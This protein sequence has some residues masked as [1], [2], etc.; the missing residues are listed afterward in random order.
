[1]TELMDT[2]FLFDVDNTLLDNDRIQSDLGKHLAENYGAEVRDRFGVIF[3]Q[4]RAELGYADYLGALERYRLEAMHDPKVLRI[5]NWLVDYPFQERLYPNA[6][7]VVK[8][9]KQA[10]VTAILS[11]GDAVF[12]PRK[13]EKSGLWPVFGDNVLIYVHKELELADVES[14]FPARHYVLIDDKL[15]ILDAVKRVWRD[16]VTTVFPRQGHYAADQRILSE[17]PPADITIDQIGELL[18]YDLAAL[19]KR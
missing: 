9:A 6:I 8:T 15:R 13:I 2:V 3:E 1:M 11:D 4:L 12:Q 5:A 18:E 14:H 7:E 17:F 16:R 19:V 10:G